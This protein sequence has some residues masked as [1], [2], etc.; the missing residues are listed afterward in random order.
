M[1][2]RYRESARVQSAGARRKRKLEESEVSK[3][4][5]AHFGLQ[6]KLLQGLHKSGNRLGVIGGESADRLLVRRFLGII[7]LGE[8]TDDL[9][10]TK[11]RSF[12][13]RAHLALAFGTM[14]TSALGFVDCAAVIGE[15]CLW[16][17]DPNTKSNCEKHNH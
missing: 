11:A 9:V 14:A 15:R 3:S 7:A 5:R 12:Q 10:L 6:P 16:E 1:K 13:S 4:P 2:V 8:N 17:S